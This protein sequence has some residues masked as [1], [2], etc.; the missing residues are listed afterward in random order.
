MAP[1]ASVRDGL[2]GPQG[3][4]LEAVELLAHPAAGLIAGTAGLD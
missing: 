1:A 3:D 4:F 2:P